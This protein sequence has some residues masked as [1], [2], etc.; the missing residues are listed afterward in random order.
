MSRATDERGRDGS[1]RQ[2]LRV[3]AFHVDAGALQVEADGQATRLTPKAMGVLL[4][5]AREPGVTVSRDELLDRVWGSVH[6]TP[7]VVGHAITALRRAFGDDLERPAY[8]E[9][10]PRIGYRLVAPVQAITVADTADTDPDPAT[11]GT[12]AGEPAPETTPAAAEAAAPVL[13]A[14][15]AGAPVA[16]IPGPGIESARRWRRP[17]MRPGLPIALA[18]VLLLLGVIAWQRATQ[19]APPGAAIAAEHVRRVTFAPG[20]EASPRLNPGGDWM[21]YTRRERLDAPPRLFLQ[22]LH[23]TEPIALADGDHAERPTWSPDGR[24][25]AYVWRP[26]DNDGCEIRSTSIDGG[27]QLKLADCPPHSVVYLDW[28]P[29]DADQIAYSAVIPGSPGGT[30]IQLL[31]RAQGWAPE[32][33]DYGTMAT[34]VDLYPRFS[35]DGSRIAFRRGSNPT[36]DLY[37]VATTTGGEATRL[38]R[39]RSEIV[40]FDWLPDGSGLVLSS[41]HEGGRALYSLSLSS[42]QVTALG[43]DDASSPDIANR[44]W[45]LAFALESWR[46]SLAEYPLDGGPRRLLAPS[47]GRDFSAAM[48][49]DDARVVFA[50]DR[51]GSSQLWL[52][53]RSD[54]KTRRL[55]R[56]DAGRVEAPLLSADGRRVL[57]VLRTSGRHEV[58]E[59]DLEQGVSHQVA[60]AGSS[61]R[62]AIYGSD[63]RSIWY[64]SWHGDGWRLH[65]CP[66]KDS[67]PGCHGQ[68]T[69]LPAFRVA[70]ATVAGREALLL[71]GGNDGGLVSAVAEDDLRPLRIAAMSIEEPW[72]VV[73]GAVWSAQQ[74][75]AGTLVLGAHS[76]HDGT[77]TPLGTMRGARL[78][79]G[80]G[81]QVSADR[82]HLVLP[83]ITE[84]RTDI[85]VSRLR[86]GNG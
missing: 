8:I 76:L 18:A 78:L 6:V 25:I 40:G 31:R 16:R 34:P 9:T 29:A 84:N 27:G 32:P 39:L 65:A 53:D 48:S 23:G 7:G 85:G 86:P 41:N 45:N 26:A 11:P 50:S 59:F 71:A 21:V 64:T 82:R 67:A 14:D 56:H 83:V 35:P 44:G 81:F 43:I 12:A 46:S 33:F 68:P 1:H 80:E 79:L 60:V 73:D 77:W 4:A 5:L 51:D 13:P 70:R 58:H 15:Q 47:S 36:S 19:T 49:A 17:A 55:T 61:L 66:R 52:L 20:S 62:N 72:Q 3:G 38:T 24:E 63:D 30:R 37:A 42:G 28:N 54:G 75:E 10:I 74:G 22:S 69:A 57:Y 2:Q